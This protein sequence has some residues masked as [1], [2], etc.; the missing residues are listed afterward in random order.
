MAPPPLSYHIPLT[1]N[2]WPALGSDT[3]FHFD[4]GTCC[5]IHETLEMESEL[6]GICCTRGTEGGEEKELKV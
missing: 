5:I 1:L 6:Q 3:H 2:L 4:E